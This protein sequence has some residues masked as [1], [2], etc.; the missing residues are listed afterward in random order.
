M[1]HLLNLFG[2]VLVVSFCLPVAAFAAAHSGGVC[3]DCHKSGANPRSMSNVCNNLECHSTVAKG[4]FIA[5]KASNALGSHPA[6]PTATKQTAHFWGGSSSTKVAAGSTNPPSTFYSSRYSISTKRITC[7]ICHDPHKAVGT[8]LLRKTLDNDLICQQC[9][10]G[11]YKDTTN[12]ILTHPVGSTAIY[13]D[14]VI[15][16]PTKYKAVPENTLNGEVGLV[17]G[18]VS[19]SSCHAPHFADS[20]SSTIDGL[21]NVNSLVGDGHLLKANGPLE[22][23]NSA[24][25]QSCHTYMAH[26]KMSDGGESVG[27][28]T[29]HSGHIVVGNS[30]VFILRNS[31]TTATFGTETITYPA[32]STSWNDNVVVTANGYCEKCHG[33]AE[34]IP[35]G[36][37][38]HTVDA[39]CRDCHMHQ[40]DGGTYSF[41]NDANAATCGDCHG[42]PPY[43][44][45]RGDRNTGGTDGGYAY[46][47]SSHNYLLDA[48]WKDESKTPHNAHAG[49]G[50]AQGGDYIFGSG[51]LACDPC[52]DGLSQLSTHNTTGYRDLAW[53]SLSKAGTLLSP[54]YKTDIPNQWTCSTVYCHSNGGKR[55][56]SGTKI[57]G[58]YSTVMTPSWL[59]GSNPRTLIGV[60]G[61]CAVCHGN[62]SATMT[63]RSNS[64]SHGK[65]LG[66]GTLLKTYSCS[67][68][69]NQTATSNTALAAGARIITTGGKHVNGS[70]DVQFN[71]TFNLGNGT[72][73][74]GSYVGA[75]T[76]TCT[77]Y[78]HSNGK[79]STITTPDWD[80]AASGACGTCHSTSAGSL[81][82]P[83]AKHLAITL[84]APV[85]CND[86]HFTVAGDATLGTHTGHV[87]GAFTFSQTACNSCHGWESGELTPAWGQ[88]MTDGYCLTCHTGPTVGIVKTMTAPTKE[89]AKTRGHN[90]TVNYA[91]GNLPGNKLC[92]SCHLTTITNH[93][94]VTDGDATHL[95]AA[96]ATCTTS[97][98]G[99]G[100]SAVKDGII[101]HV[102]KGC[103]ACHDPHG[104]TTQTNIYMVRSKSTGNFTSD[105]TPVVFTN[106]GNDALPLTAV[107]SFDEDDGAAGHPG[108]VNADDLCATCHTVAGGSGHN[109]RDNTPTTGSH[110][111][112]ET[113]MTGLCHKS[114]TE[115]T[116]AFKSGG[117][118]ACNSCHDYPPNTG[119]HGNGTNKHTR[120]STPNKDTE[121]RTDCAFCHTGSDLYTYDVS[122]DQAAGGARGNHNMG[123]ANQKAVL[124]AAVGYNATNFNCT[125]AC[126]LSTVG[127][128]AWNDANGLNCTACHYYVA[129]AT[130]SANNTAAAPKDLKGSHNAHFAKTKPCTSCH[131]V[132]T[133][134]THI[135]IPTGTDIEKIQSRAAALQN[136]ADVLV[137]IATQNDPGNETCSGAGVALGCHNTKIT[138]A[139]G[140]GS[141]TCTNCHMVTGSATADPKTGL[142]NIGVTEAAAGVQKH[143]STLPGGGCTACHDSTKPGTHTDGTFNDD[144]AVRTDR[145]LTVKAG[146]FVDNATANRGTC[147]GTGNLT[148]C[149]SDSG[150]W[151][152]FW[153]TEANSTAT[154]SGA[155]RC[156]V[157]HGQYS[158]LS[159]SAG[160]GWN[161]GTT[162]FKTYGGATSTRGVSHKSQ[163]GENNAC[164]DCHSYATLTG[165]HDTVTHLVTMNDDAATV[166][167]TEAASRV[168]C[169]YCHATG[170]PLLT[171]TYTFT[172]SLFPIQRVAGVNDPKQECNNC[173]GDI[174]GRYWPMGVYGAGNA[175]NDGGRHEIHMTRLAKAKYNMTVVALLADGDVKN[176]QIELCKYCHNATVPGANPGHTDTAL[177]AE[178]S[179]TMY[180]LWDTTRTTPDAV[181]Y[182]GTGANGTGTCAN[183]NCH[184]GKNTNS[185][186]NFTWH[187]TGT[188]NCLLCHNDITNTT[189]GTT[190]ATHAAHTGSAA[191]FGKTLNCAS[192][193][194]GSVTWS[195]YVVPTNDLHINGAFNVGTAGGG[196]VPFTYSGTYTDA[197]TRVVGSC[198][199]N[200]CHNNGKNA[201]A[202]AYTWQTAIAGC[203]ACHATSSALGGNSHT[204]HLTASFATTFGKTANCQDCHDAV[205]AVSMAGK[206]A[207]M[208]GA[209]TLAAGLTY[210]G[211]PGTLDVTLATLGDCTGSCHTNGKAAAP[212][213]AAI[214][215]STYT[216]CNICHGL[217]NSAGNDGARHLKHIGNTAK[218][219]ASCGE[220]HLTATT[221]T[222]NS[223]N[224]LN[225]TVNTGNKI[226]AHT[227]GTETCTNSCH[228]VNS[229]RGDWL[230]TAALACTDCHQIGSSYIG[231]A[232]KP[233][234]ATPNGLHKATVALAHDDIFGA[235]GTCT[236]CHT[237]VTVDSPA[238]HVNGVNTDAN[239][240]Y[241]LFA[242]YNTSTNTCYASCHADGGDWARKWI[243]VVD[244]KP[245]HTDAATAAVCGNC[246]GSF[247]QG[248]RFVN[249]A[250]ASTTDHTDPETV[251]NTD[252]QMNTTG[253]QV[254]SKCHGWGVAAYQSATK[255][256]NN[257]LTMNSDLGYT[258]GT[259]GCTT[260]CH[261]GKTLTM[262]SNSG[263]TNDS[264]AYGVLSCGS[265]HNDG[266]I[267]P[268]SGAHAAHGAD[269]DADYTECEACHGT[270]NGGSWAPGTGGSHNTGTV[271]FAAGIT[272]SNGGT[273]GTDAASLNDTCTT[274]QCHSPTGNSAT[275]GT[276]ASVACNECHYYEA[277]ASGANNTA[278]ANALSTSHNKHFNKSKVCA[279][280]HGTL[281]T[282]RTHINDVTGANA[283]AILTGKA[284]AVQNEAGVSRALVTWDDNANTCT[285]NGGGLAL[286]CHASGTP[287]W[288]VTITSCIIC[289][290]DE[291][292]SAVNPT[293]GLH[294][295]TVATRHDDT[296]QTGVCVNCHDATSPSSLHQNGTKN[297][298]A[299]AT[300]TWNATKV[301]SYNSATGCSANCHADAGDWNRKW[302][303][304]VNAL[305]LY[306]DL[307]TAAVCDNCHGSFAQGWNFVNEGNASTTDHTDPDADNVGDQM[308]A[309]GHA[310]CTKCHGWGVAGYQTGTKHKNNNLTMNSDL[311][312]VDGTGGCT[313]NCHKGMTLTAKTNS[314]FITDTG[315][316]GAPSCG[317]CHDDGAIP[318]NSGAHAIHGSDADADYTECIACHGDNNGKGYT[319]YTDLHST[320]TV[321]FAAGI[322]YSN[323]GTAGTNAAAANDTCTTTQC[324]SAAGNPATWGTP[325]SVGC[326]AC[327]YYE[328]VT[329][330]ANNT[331]NANALTATH[332]VHFNKGK[333]CTDC[334]GTLPTNRTHIAAKAGT[335]GV[336]LT[337]K[338]NAAQ[339]DADPVSRSGM[340]WDDG[341]NTCGTAGALGCHNSK[342]TPGWGTSGIT[343][344]NCH[345]A[346]GGAAYD[347]TSGLHNMTA[348]NVQK[349][350]STLRTGCTECHASMTSDPASHIDGTWLAD[351][352]TNQTVGG[353]PRFLSGT[354]TGMVYSEG[355]A[356]ASTCWDNGATGASTSL[357]YN[358]GASCH[359]DN[360]VWK[361][362]WSTNANVDTSVST[363]PGQLVCDV[364][365]GQYQS[366]NGS[367][368]G[369][370]EGSVH[371]R[372]GADG[373]LENKGVTHNRVT[374]VTNACQDC[375][376]YASAAPHENGVLNFDGLVTNNPDT[377]TLTMGTTGWYCAT[378][379]N[380]ASA[381]VA[382]LTTSH[383]FPAS[384]AITTRAYVAGTSYPEGGCTGCHGNSGTG[385][386]WPD[387]STG[388][389]ANTAGVHADHVREI[390]KKLY[391]TGSPSVA[392]QNLTCNYCHPGNTHG[393]LDGTLPAD[394]SRTDLD[395]SGTI[396]I[397][398]PEQGTYLKKIIGGTNDTAGF[399]RRTP[400]TCSN[401][402]CHAGAPFTPHW[403]VDNVVPGTISDLAAVANAEPGTVKLTWT[404]PGDDDS[405]DGTIYRYDVRYSTATINDG[406]FAAATQAKAPS[407]RRKGALES[408]IVNGLIPGTTYYFAV[409]AYDEVGN[410]SAISNVPSRVAQ[411]DNVAPVFWG[412]NAASSNDY[413]LDLTPNPD[414]NSVNVSWDAGR[415]HSHSL[416]TPL[417]YLVL[418]SEYS[419]RTHFTNAGPM[420]AT[421]G[422][423]SCFDKTDVPLLPVTCGSTVPLSNEYRI[424]SAQTTALNYDVKNLPVGTVYNFLVRSKDLAGNID[425]NRAE[426]MAMAKAT[427]YQTIAL[428]TNLTSAT[429][430][431]AAGTWTGL[432]DSGTGIAASDARL[433]AAYPGTAPG[434]FSLGTTPVIWSPNTTY[435]QDTNVWGLSYQ[436]KITGGNSPVTATYQFGYLNGTVFTGFGVPKTLTI[437]KKLARVYKFPLSTYKGKIPAGSKPAFI[438][439][440]AAT[441]TLT[442]GSTTNKGGILLFNQQDYND[443]PTGLGSLSQSQVNS[444]F[445]GGNLYRLTWTA[446]SAVNGGQSV[447]YDVFGSIDGGLTYPYT[448]GRNLTTNSVDW[449]PVGDGITGNQTNVKFKVLAGD[450]F[451][452]GDMLIDVSNATNVNHSELA[453]GTFTVNNTVDIWTPAAIGS[454]AGTADD[455]KVETRPKQG[456]VA[457]SWKAVGNDGFNHGT[458]AT[459][460]D[461]RFN[462]V[463]I[464][465]ANWAASTPATNEPYPDFTG[466]IESYELLGLNPDAPYYFAMKVGDA[467]GNWS[468]ISNVAS[469]QSGPKCGIC[470]STPPDESATAGNHIEHGYTM[471]DCAKCHGTEAAT[472]TTAHQDGALKLGWNTATPTA[473]TTLSGMT[474]TYTQG[475]NVIY[476][477]TNGSG[478]FVPTPTI[479]DGIDSGTCSGFAATNTS[480][481][482]GP[483][484]PA[485]TAGTVLDC[486]ACHGTLGRTTD[487]YSRAFDATIDNAMVVPDQVKAS[488]AVDNHGGSTGKYVGAHLKHLNSSFRLAKGD[489][490][491][492]CHNDS[493]HADGLVDV[494]YD[495]NVTGT[496]A[497]WTPNAGGAGT[498]G[499]CGGTNVDNCH[500]SNVP[501]WDTAATV[502]CNQC[503]GF[504]GMD[505][506]VGNTTSAIGHVKDGT[507]VRAC[508]WCHP[509][510]HPQGTVQDPNAVMIPNNP[511]VGIA[512][513]SGGIHLLKNINSRGIKTTEA[514][515]CW[516]CHDAQA[517]KVTEWAANNDAN[518]GST[519]YNY[520]DIFTDVAFGTT[521][522]NWLG[523]GT[524][525]YWRSGTTAFQTIKKGKIQSTHSTAPGATSTV[526]YDGTN[527]RYNEDLD[528]VADIRCSNCHDVH[529]MNK[530][531]NDAVS[532]T[533]YLRGT[534]MGNPYNE[535]GPPL[536]TTTYV[537]TL[538]NAGNFGAVPRGGT[539]Y[540]RLGGYFIDQ[541]NVVPMTASATVTA[542]LN[543]YPTAGWTQESSAGLCI[544]CHGNDVD[545]MDQKTGESLW[546]GT[547]GHSNS[548]IGGT[549]TNSFNIF[550]T[551]VGTASLSG[552]PLPVTVTATSYTTAVPN[553]AYQ[554]QGSNTC[555]RGYGYR[556]FS[557]ATTGGGYT[558]AVGTL[559]A[560]LAYDWGVTVDDTTVDQMYH[561]FSCSKCHNPHASRLPKLLITNCLDVQHNTWDDDKSLQA[562]YTATTL[563]DVDKNAAGTAGYRSA[564]YASAQNCH[565][566]NNL[567]T[568]A[569]KGGWNKVSP[570]TTANQ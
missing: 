109:N 417:N 234:R 358:A 336:V 507:T 111:Q 428:Q 239:T 327:H 306:T 227:N 158:T 444:T 6:P 551:G 34:L 16:A 564:Y 563:R 553:M 371:Y 177:P 499:T 391:S 106:R 558:P 482:H 104:D 562:T 140:A 217:P 43:L 557:G 409:K 321:N 118:S 202:P 209:V 381:D 100:G 69:H 165:N 355:A 156:N 56:A 340:T 484:A 257:N 341:L 175:A 491:K 18:V 46:V 292:T 164:E 344:T 30:N 113:C 421:I 89:H 335:D 94:N 434:T 445:I 537:G 10:T 229:A 14:A 481:C 322:T 12:A 447:H 362:Q 78:C 448:I 51:I 274:T 546:L 389:A 22:A 470:H 387:S 249:E 161:A 466:A 166:Q 569:N 136:E 361:R 559:Y 295:F 138:P 547:N 266:A 333:L 353:Q 375:H 395:N 145:F 529:N 246:H 101:T 80:L 134:T 479:G 65:H 7:S 530:A 453:S 112:G 372:S 120:I 474:I 297:T 198:A 21:V 115:A 103:T 433:D 196:S 143:D 326:N 473:A 430:P 307:A 313:V 207:H 528:A 261:G 380:T 347:P 54:A 242:N 324:H 31:V 438:L 256:Q 137:A 183:A 19:C 308:N 517:T 526:V 5:D 565:R 337:L 494:A 422:T 151:T 545:N 265:C 154:A 238:S 220:C 169:A 521:T 478:G 472:F 188:Q 232:A 40:V 191:T 254:C 52:H 194:G 259:G 214:W 96:A 450:G 33:S 416:T 518:T 275:W 231:E 36:A 15:A 83:H 404:T 67:T 199:V 427:T 401:V 396:N 414:T 117:G 176:K 538:V 304:A 48:N 167:V 268:N 237:G 45:A 330:G 282:D 420:P 130:S 42:F 228:L 346:G 312:Y 318:P 240:T 555:T 2:M 233:V 556:N 462:T 287:D 377:F 419:L 522:S 84:P 172:Q 272:Y 37:Q 374:G 75:A 315:A 294:N 352:P 449:D 128:G 501:Q 338:A 224:H 248:W 180:A 226:S 442:Y 99:V 205:S 541:N 350:N 250:G 543:E 506:T 85:T 467:I 412:I 320:G 566:Y 305:P 418:W 471:A 230:D 25:C 13:A 504:A 97:C 407:G 500:G 262:Q 28:Q 264:G 408:I 311:G 126:H 206:T 153:S 253:H 403:Y 426:L 174:S 524:G 124:T 492:L 349:H 415:D 35:K 480:G 461:I 379:H 502:A 309:A 437:G 293:S 531:P 487:Q 60:A 270:D 135:S 121:D 520:G 488:P 279:D 27:C 441:V 218:V 9:H 468:P 76:G 392:E 316:Y 540:R 511:L 373:A 513:R 411:V 200:L 446:A 552:R 129:G 457:L 225:S 302:T 532:G 483:A 162:H 328:A 550:D 454:A 385:G 570:W 393:G 107:Q 215:N 439:K 397:G 277:S 560:H 235:G 79:G 485:W 216:N 280:C 424:K 534:W 495:L 383:T 178:V 303:G 221:T 490:C 86:C 4:E 456:S 378:C 150:N 260:N 508:I 296:L 329:N 291:T 286:G 190:G 213:T 516:A 269:A 384:T 146:M 160:L 41:Q 356:N 334:H 549:F 443:L 185:V 554:A 510:G 170:D 3:N 252:D 219:A 47:N 406:N 29:C 49:G 222:Y 26:G 186:A 181:T 509:A 455:L 276:P 223:A 452:S 431:A 283:G 289:H 152:R 345:L 144:T 567:R 1:R 332:T 50:L 187:G 281:P 310:V 514:E 168:Y 458:R 290:T 319:D 171:G 370:R 463:T 20:K 68:C 17:N 271:N 354:R 527:K 273:P 141:I 519:P 523:S 363:A 400:G 366:L 440:A 394:V 77:T 211:A 535:D 53:N 464:N 203:A 451:R 102:S 241:G 465:D 460:Y 533:P 323:G 369:W 90:A 357:D 247:A 236:S 359:R 376:A 405:L 402:A 62:T 325:A 251:D 413:N 114:H 255:H 189:A 243:G 386:F 105:A 360:G 24:L 368:T 525:A 436:I 81:S 38:F 44:N 299:T 342:T 498:P 343:C 267:P 486:S 23:D 133:D 284:N 131:T 57:L 204:A 87:D 192:C 142:H 244:A 348:A 515:V 496:G 201:A 98:H 182:T 423:D 477:D 159:G 365:H 92:T 193:H 11:L 66:G 351:G 173:H 503:H 542:A 399:W 64:P 123:D 93:V 148:G 278:N 459:Q 298:S 132:P 469:T 561:Q 157:C 88:S 184:N 539:N 108:E 82:S 119:A 285:N 544:L 179:S 410:P 263:F 74:A 110:H 212:V 425:T 210:S 382:T 314:G 432:F 55:N 339:N 195:P 208:N 429:I 149:H 331:A 493:I 71:S 127:D 197:A 288:D 317:G 388:H 95:I 32:T 367:S 536:S 476:T 116:G 398:D 61:E 497:L 59:D 91:S 139:W 125:T 568:V 512:Y 155:A 435:A 70:V 8:K 39:V 300:F 245:L 364:C 505:Y 301:L 390:A 258:D 63:S 122:S 163:G 489:N 73:G 58:D 72:L 147:S 548:A 475:G